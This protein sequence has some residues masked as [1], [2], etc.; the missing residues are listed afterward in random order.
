MGQLQYTDHEATK[1]LVSV[2]ADSRWEA[3]A[4]AR[5]VEALK[6]GASIAEAARMAFD[7]GL[8]TLKR[9]KELLLEAEGKGFAQIL[10]PR[11]RI[12]SAENPVTKLFPAT[13]TEERFLDLLEDLSQ[14]SHLTIQDHRQSGHSLVDFSLTDGTN[15]L[16]INVK[17]AG[18]AFRQARQLVG[19]EPEDCIPIP[20]YKAHGAFEQEPNLI[21]AVSPDYQLIAKINETLQTVLSR[22]ELISWDLL[23]RFE[24]SRLRTGEDAFVF[25]MVRKYRR[26]LLA[27]CSAHQFHVI[28]A[29]KAI[30]ILQTMPQRTPGIGLR[31]WGTGASAEVNVHVSVKEDMKRWEVIVEKIDA[32]G[33]EAVVR[34]V[35]R[36]RMEEVYDPEI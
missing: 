12:G 24:G 19:L 23:S 22:D 7:S 29:R 32:G 9:S 33:I 34:A 14:R 17:N 4:L 8:S 2:L 21:Y 25:G 28:S 31:A 18:T 20:A 1:A 6:G 13:I 36:K 3:V 30:R 10:T 11:S 16:P 26:E 35:N 27:C 15:T 5:G